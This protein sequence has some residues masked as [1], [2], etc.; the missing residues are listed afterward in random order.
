MEI[1]RIFDL[2]PYYLETFEPKDDVLAGKED[3]KW[4]KYDINKYVEI[5]NNISYGLMAL[6]IKKGDK[7]G[8]ILGNR[9]EWNMLDMGIM[10]TGAVHVPIY[11]TISES[12]YKYILNHSEVKYVFIEGK[13][14]LKKVE[15]I[16]P[17]I[18]GVKDVYTINKHE[19][20]KHLSELIEL[21]KTNENETKLKSL[22]SDVAPNDLATLIYTSGTTGN[23]KGVMLS[24]N[25]IVSNVLAIR[26]IVPLDQN[27]RALSYLPLC[28][29][30]ERVLIYL[31]ASLGIS[32]YYAE[33]IAKIADNL[34]EVKPD[35]FVTVPRLLEKIYDKIIDKGRK[36]PFLKK[37][38]FFWAIRLG[39][40]FKPGGANSCIYRFKLKIA[41]KLIFS[42]WRVAFGD[43]IKLVVSGGAALQERLSRVF[44]AAGIKV[45]EGYGLTE[46]SPVISVCTMEEDGVKFGTVGPVLT[47]VTVKIAEDGEIL[48]KGPNIMLGYFKEPELT[49]ES[50][51]NAGW[52]HTG[53]IGHLDEEGFLKI[54]GRKKLIFKTS[55]GKYVNPQIIENKFKESPFIDNMLV[56]GENQKFA[57]ALI[58]PSFDHL[59]QW[60]EYKEIEYTTNEEMIVLP[61]IKKRFLKEVTKYNEYF[62]KAEKIMKYEV[63]GKEWTVDNGELSASM[64]MKRKFICEE[65]RE[66]ID[67]IF[68]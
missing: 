41:N 59:K 31:Y 38:I 29:V 27:S 23:P 3:G 19:G 35:M 20:V 7:V 11:P 60:C 26:E 67:S 4:I 32:I 2:L 15:H 44:T 54:T 39:L 50:I 17:E 33:S 53:D 43:N 46:A 18:Q 9:P 37:M 6:G 65:Y 12:D 63:M 16:L 55:L 10:Q 51:D 8:T 14:L 5:V 58:V 1:T 30:F 34:R 62:G 22:M 36:L 42:K 52:L 57:A 64:K 48:A 47:G 61:R 28:H 66:V 56:M 68:S 40:K 24:H 49:K 25:N 21:G 45:L 13:E